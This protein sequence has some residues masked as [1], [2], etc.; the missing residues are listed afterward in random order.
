MTGFVPRDL[1]ETRALV[2]GGTSGI[3]FA[4]AQSL[5]AAGVPS[6]RIA[7]RDAERGARAEETLRA[8]SPAAD[9]AFVRADCADPAAAEAMANRA[10]QE[11][12]GID[13]LVASAG[14]NH[15]PQLLFRTP[16]ESV[17]AVVA[18]DL[19]PGLLACRA[20]LPH[21]I[22]AGGGAVIAVASDAAKIATPGETVIGAVMSATV[23]FVRGLAVEGKRNGIRA[24]CVTPSLVEGTPLTD[25]LME[26]GTFS[27][28]LFAK[29]RPLA[30]LGP[31][32]PDDLAA[33]IV[34]LAGPK[35][36]KITGQAISVNGGIS[37]A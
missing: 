28:R 20:A 32:T 31:T 26:E 22:E 24:N 15:R 37:A 27:S 33:L 3:G 10:A 7:G 30:A 18:D 11:M 29:A 21:L 8:G 23:Q 14:G 36:A 12:G 19:L 5:L 25:R 17:A 9:V 4:T 13:L 6:L 35:A 2:V 16:I 34:F 1:A